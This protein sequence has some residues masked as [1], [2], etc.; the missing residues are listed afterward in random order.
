MSFENQN[1]PAIILS[2]V[3]SGDIA[4][5]MVRVIQIMVISQVNL[6]LLKLLLF[7]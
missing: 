4:Y 5:K 1:F 2:E 7:K 3:F 6:V